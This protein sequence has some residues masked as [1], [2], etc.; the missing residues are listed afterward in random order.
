[1]RIA[2]RGA[3]R[4]A[5]AFVC[6]ACSGADKSHPQG[7]T[8]YTTTQQ[9]KSDAAASDGQAPEPPCTPFEKRECSIDLGIVNGVH[10]CTQGIQICEDGEWSDCLPPPL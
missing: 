1:M 10:N 2:V 4:G 3:L 6:I 8:D 7:G 5:L 9:F